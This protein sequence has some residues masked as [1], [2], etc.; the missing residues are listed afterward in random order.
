[1]QV[2][3]LSSIKLSTVQPM[4]HCVRTLFGAITDL[5]ISVITQKRIRN[6]STISELRQEIL[7]LQQGSREE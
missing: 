7:W 2:Q 3:E 5:V 6:T 1:M 4:H